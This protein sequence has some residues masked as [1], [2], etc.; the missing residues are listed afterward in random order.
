VVQ[1]MHAVFG[2]G[3]DLLGRLEQGHTPNVENERQKLLGLVQGDSELQNSPMYVGDQTPAVGRGG[4][5]TGPLGNVSGQYLGVRYALACWADEVM[6]RFAP[7]W[8]AD[9]WE[10]DTLEV[11][12]YGGAQE[13]AWR[14]WE[15]AKRAEGKGGPEALEAYLWAVMLGFR[16]EPDQAAP[17]V[18]PKEW[19]DGVRR[20]VLQV[21]QGD[22]PL[23]VDRDTVTRVPPL[24]GRQKLRAMLRA[25]AVVLAAGVF[26]LALSVTAGLRN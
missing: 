24:R 19:V 20:R 11:R 5:V 15:Q 21:R 7:P 3:L 9:R 12:L 14:F 18:V 8:W 13:R 17:P 2:A 23:P 6:L 25:F 10:S 22:F 4:G 16:G 26:L 1:Q